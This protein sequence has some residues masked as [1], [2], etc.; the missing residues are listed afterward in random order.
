M[1]ATG[2]L[3]PLHAKLIGA[4]LALCAALPLAAAT[5]PVDDAGAATN[6]PPFELDCGFDGYVVPGAWY[7]VRA[8]LPGDATAFQVTLIETDWCRERERPLAVYEGAVTRRDGIAEGFARARH[9]ESWQQMFLRCEATLASGRRVSRDVQPES[10]SDSDLLTL[11]VT[12]TPREFDFLSGLRRE[13]RGD[14][15]V[16]PV[17]VP[18]FPSDARDLALAR[19]VILDSDQPPLPAQRDALLDWVVKG[20]TV[21]ATDRLLAAR[22][23][24]GLRDWFPVGEW[25]RAAGAATAAGPEL[26]RLTG[27]E[28]AFVEALPVT[29]LA[30]TAG[31]VT[32]SA[33]DSGLAWGRDTG[34]GRVV[35]LAADW[36][37]PRLKDP[38][39][40]DRVR[41]AIWLNT[42]ALARPV[43]TFRLERE[44]ALPRE[45]R[46]RFLVKPLALFLLVYVA[47][48][49]PVNWLVLRRLKRMEYSLWTLPL[50]ALTFAAIAFLVGVR[51]RTTDTVIHE[52]EVTPLGEGM[53]RAPVFGIAG[54]LAPD[55]QPY[56][57]RLDDPF[58]ILTPAGE[59]DDEAA[60]RAGVESYAAAHPEGP[61]IENVRVGT[62]SMRFHTRDS[63]ARFAGAFE[64]GLTGA[65]HSLTGLVRNGLGVALR[66]AYLIHRWNRASLGDW[67]AD[68]SRVLRLPLTPPTRNSM[69]RCPN[70]GRFHG[71]R[72]WFDEDACKD[73]PLPED[74]RRLLATLSLP[75]GPFV[76]GWLDAA[77]SPRL[78]V[79][80]AIT[81]GV[82]R[83][84]CI[85]ALPLHCAGPRIELP[86]G[87]IEGAGDRHEDHPLAIAD[88]RA[89][90]ARLA[91]TPPEAFLDRDQ[92]PDAQRRRRLLPEWEN[93]THDAREVELRFRL[94]FTAARIAAARLELWWDAGEPDPDYPPAE[95]VLAVFDHATGDWREIERR[96]RGDE[97]LVLDDAASLIATPHPQVRVRIS[98]PRGDRRASPAPH[99][100]ELSG[101]V[102]V[103][104]AP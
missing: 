57:L 17:G 62:W 52:C 56:R 90:P 11:A 22:D 2:T 76:A 55:E 96:E 20:G 77:A 69:P 25:P 80:R 91:L 71:G 21:I 40:L 83:R 79:D 12:D 93:D 19:V 103:A 54:I 81:R 32:L 43:E 60:Q 41:R 97:R 44:Q 24:E 64:G 35:L 63:V 82:A 73:Q 15:R 84:L 104:D 70:C 53:D 8:V 18:G 87:L 10:I 31:G 26:A 102:E 51:L 28:T 61:R 75:D 50:G 100:L 38:A 27:G 59:K 37:R 48:M 46:V 66:D 74:M 67:P 5:P 98:V 4:S 89:L 39:A 92:N 95:K 58:A 99:Y 86:V 65:A 1:R 36:R 47:L 14:V 29:R 23:G 45:A 72:G 101:I 13:N 94:P 88:L 34:R 33:G 78:T 49:G 85:A 7:P 9:A 42:L 3:M 68:E 6:P 30:H 16:W